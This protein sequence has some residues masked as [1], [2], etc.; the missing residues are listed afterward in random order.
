[1]ATG[2]LPVL[3]GGA[4]R[5]LDYLPDSNKRYLATFRLGETTD[6]QDCTGTVL[7][8]RPVTADRAAVEAALSAFGARSCRCRPC[9]RR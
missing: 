2:V 7:T 1:M 9:T 3:L 6:T 4:T 5:F 8:R